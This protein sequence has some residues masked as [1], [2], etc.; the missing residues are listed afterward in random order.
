MELFSQRKGIRPIRKTIQRESMDDELRNM[1]WNCTDLVFANGE[2]RKATAVQRTVGNLWRYYFKKPVDA[3]QWL[4]YRNPKSVYRQIRGWFFQAEWWQVYDFMEALVE[5]SGDTNKQLVWCVNHCLET[6]SA[7]YRFVSNKVVEITD[8]NEIES[9]E[10]AISEGIQAVG[11]HLQRSLELVSDRQECDYR[12]AIKESISAVE[13]ACRIVAK[14]DKATLSDC[15]KV[16]KGKGHLHS[17]FEDALSKLYGYSS[18]G[19]GI[20]HALVSDEESPSFAD[21]KFML[22]ACSA[23]CSYLWTKAAEL[24]FDVG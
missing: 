2:S 13:A 20:R 1:L 14:M 22:V 5:F 7:A 19:S 8:D 6:E 15:L 9:I 11:A 18:D 10:S 21:A 4:P 3:I 16:I 12:N 24:D 17:A 23:F